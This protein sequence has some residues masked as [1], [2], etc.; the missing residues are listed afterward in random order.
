MYTRKTNREEQNVKMILK[1]KVQGHSENVYQ[2]AY[3]ANYWS[4]GGDFDKE[5]Y[6]HPYDES[7]GTNCDLDFQG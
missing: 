1:G 7:W 5:N 6:V 4:Y 3:L 2:L